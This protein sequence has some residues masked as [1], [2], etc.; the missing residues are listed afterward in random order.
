LI[1]VADASA[2]ITLARIGQLNLLRQVA[3]T[4]YIPQA[5]YD[6]VVTRGAG[7]PGTFEIA[8]AEWIS[9]AIARDRTAVNRLR[10]RIGWGEAEAI[11]LAREL[12]ADA[13]I[14]DDATAR[15]VGEAEGQ[16]VLGILGPL[17]EARSRG[18][19]SAV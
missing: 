7:K 13:V 3:G 2:L 16:R 5:V 15:R 6:E 14:L 4:T 10:T 8:Q 18:I 17:L 9:R 19:L 12:G 11:V 1:L